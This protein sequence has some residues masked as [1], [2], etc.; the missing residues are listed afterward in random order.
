MPD[1]PNKPKYKINLGDFVYNTTMKLG[2][3]SEKDIA[4]LRNIWAFLRKPARKNMPTYS[5]G[6]MR[7]VN[8]MAKIAPKKVVAST[9][10]ATSASTAQS[11][12]VA[13]ASVAQSATTAQVTTQPTTQATTQTTTQPAAQ[14]NYRGNPV[15][16]LRMKTQQAGGIFEHNGVT[17]FGP[18]ADR[19]QVA[20]AK[21]YGAKR[22][23][24]GLLELRR[25]VKYQGGPRRSKTKNE[26]PPTR[27]MIPPTREE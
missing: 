2:G 9:K 16:W 19:R 8:E 20:W 23:D 25:K 27:E 12:Q 4:W 24:S 1:K 11:N 22:G 21:E 26:K 15:D 6:A 3:M 13:P 18:G 17:Y 14:G 7:Q 5:Q 10:P